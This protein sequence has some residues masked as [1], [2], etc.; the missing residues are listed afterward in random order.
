MRFRK[1]RRKLRWARVQRSIFPYYF[2]W[3]LSYIFVSLLALIFNEW[4]NQENIPQSSTSSESAVLKI[5]YTFWTL[6]KDMSKPIARC[7][8]SFWIGMLKQKGDIR[9]TLI[10]SKYSTRLTIIFKGLNSSWNS[11]AVCD[12]MNC[13]VSEVR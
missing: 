12:S 3:T 2:Y 10:N 6:N 11:T 4:L 1:H 13:A 7:A 8:G 5:K 9:P